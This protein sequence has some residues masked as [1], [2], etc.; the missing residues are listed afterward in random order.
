MIRWAI[1]TCKGTCLEGRDDDSSSN[2]NP[3]YSWCDL[4]SKLEA[5]H[6]R[7]QAFEFNIGDE[8]SSVSGDFDYYYFSRV[9]VK[10]DSGFNSEAIVVGYGNGQEL[11]LKSYK[12]NGELISS[13][14]TPLSEL[15][16]SSFLVKNFR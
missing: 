8:A 15:K 1:K 9:I 11:E 10:T 4:S 3:L 12:K 6:E 16:N 2:Y 14:K 13:E 7:I 5:V